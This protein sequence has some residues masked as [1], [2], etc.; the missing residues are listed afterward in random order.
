VARKRWCRERLT[1]HLSLEF[2]FHVSGTASGSL[3]T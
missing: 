2:R 1:L 3:P